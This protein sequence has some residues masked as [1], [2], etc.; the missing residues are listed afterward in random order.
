M[1]VRQPT[2]L[3]QDNLQIMRDL[4]VLQIQMRDLTGYA[5]R[6]W[7]SSCCFVCRWSLSILLRSLKRFPH[8]CGS[9]GTRRSI[10]AARPTQRA[11][12]LGSV[13]ELDCV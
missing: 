13:Y 7:L 10:L 5:V 9:Q 11:S 4:A 8:H 6:C 1:G 3:L 2:P 12:W